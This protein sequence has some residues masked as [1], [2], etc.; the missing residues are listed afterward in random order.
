MHVGKCVME[1]NNYISQIHHSCSTD[2][3]ETYKSQIT[4]EYIN[5]FI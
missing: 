1:R 2:T 4:M 5:S 3:I